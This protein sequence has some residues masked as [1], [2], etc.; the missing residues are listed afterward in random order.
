MSGFNKFLQ[1]GGGGVAGLQDGTQPL[2]SSTISANN[3]DASKALKTNASRIIISTELD[4]ADTTGLQAALDSKNAN[5]MIANLDA[6]QFDIFDLN[7]IKIDTAGSG[8]DIATLEYNGTG[9][10]TID[11]DLLAAHVDSSS[12]PSINN[13][14]TVFDGVSGELIRQSTAITEVG[15]AFAGITGY[16]QL[17]GAFTTSDLSS[18]TLGASGDIDLTTASSG[19]INLN[20][21]D[22]ITIDSTSGTDIASGGLT[23]AS[24]IVCASSTAPVVNNT[25]PIWSGTTGGLL[26]ESAAVLSVAGALSSLTGLESSGAVDFDPCTT[27]SLDTT[28]NAAN[29]VSIESAGGTAVT[30][31]IKNDSGTSASSILIDST[32]GGIEFNSASGVNV[33]SGNLNIAGNPA[34]SHTSGAVVVNTIPVYADVNG[35]TVKETVTLIDGSGNL[36]AVAG[37]QANGVID[38]DTCTSLSVDTL[39]NTTNA[40]NL[41]S[42]GGT[43]ASMRMLNNT[44]T[45]VSSILIDSTAGGIQLDSASGFN[46]ASGGLNIAGNPVPAITSAPVVDNSVCTFDGTGGNIQET[47]ATITGP[48]FFIPGT[49]QSTSGGSLSIIDSVSGF[50]SAW[51]AASSSLLNLSFQM[52]NAYPSGNEAVMKFSSIGADR[53]WFEFPASSTTNAIPRWSNGTVGGFNDSS[54]LIDGSDNIT[55]ANDITQTGQLSTPENIFINTVDSGENTVYGF[56]AGINIAGTLNTVF[57]SNAGVG[58]MQNQNSFFGRWAGFAAAGGSFNTALGYQAGKDMGS[59]SNCTFVGNATGFFAGGSDN[60]ALGS[61]SYTLATGGTG[62]TMLGRATAGNLLTGSDNV[63]I[64]LSAGSA[65]TTSESDNILIRNSGVIGESGKIRIGNSTDHT[66]FIVPVNLTISNEDAS[67]NTKYGF[68]TLA[69]VSGIGNTVMGSEA[70]TGII[71][72]NNTLIGKW[73]GENATGSSQVAIGVQAGRNMGAATNCTYVGILAGLSVTGNDNVAVGSGAMLAATSSEGNTAIGRGTL[74]ALGTGDRNTVLGIDAGS[75]LTLTDS[76]N[77]CIGNVGVAGDNANIRIGNDTHNFVQIPKQLR[78]EEPGGG[79]YTGFR[80]STIQASD[81]T[82]EM[83]FNQVVDDQTRSITARNGFLSESTNGPYGR[84]F[85]YDGRLAWL[86][87]ST[88]A[89]VNCDARDDTNVKNLFHPTDTVDFATSGVLGI[90]TSDAPI[91]ANTWYGIHLIGDTS[92]GNS[93]TF[94]AI[95]DG[96]ALTQSGYDV[97]RRLGHVRTNGSSDILNFTMHHRGDIRHTI[98]D[99]SYATLELF[100]GAPTTGSVLQTLDCSSLLPPSCSM[101]D[102]HFEIDLD[103][104][105]HQFRVQNPLSGQT[106]ANCVIRLGTGIETAPGEEFNTVVSNLGCNTS[107]EIE[108]GASITGNLITITCIAFFENL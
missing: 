64:G 15:G 41:E 88:V 34:I 35:R 93:D 58:A 51:R 85:I 81:Y 107:Q 20:S 97:K 6:A 52:H 103:D 77:I 63:I 94:I 68:D 69:N 70:G 33:A 40:L 22:V 78:I 43:T 19:D 92:G 96:S 9:N 98:W 84:G 10:K 18:A 91:S 75:A 46:V 89:V 99:E 61:G 49:I 21:D 95:E 100:S 102:F 31:R 30:M 4:I 72:N 39:S 42:S 56:N 50:S 73:A 44:G 27:F 53:S 12:I 55:G 25:I 14:I 47:Q 45:S 1:S 37:L 60:T 108:W 67:T 59:N 36:S 79:N 2:F 65:Y 90:Q 87:D 5:P 3:L 105:A 48:N 101:A 24:N 83:P 74:D 11:L 104:D 82:Y 38:F 80:T 76:D 66:D 26:K 54:V 29:A 16:S 8:T 62:N 57:G 86:S 7:N 71:N 17:T 23:V 32:A 106:Y 28:M 13:R